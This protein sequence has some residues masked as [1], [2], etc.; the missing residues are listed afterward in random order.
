MR[1]ARPIRRPGSGGRIPGDA[2][3]RQEE[4]GGLPVPRSATIPSLRARQ[5]LF[6]QA[7]SSLHAA[8][9]YTVPALVDFAGVTYDVVA[10]E[11]TVAPGVF[12]VLMPGHTDGRQSRVVRCGNGTVIL[13]GQAHDLA[14]QMA[15]DDNAEFLFPRCFDGP[16]LCGV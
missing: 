16:L 15:N 8:S 9:G 5:S 13:A 14:T 4:V 7:N 1:L 10:S 11:T 2:V 6:R 3:G 12:I